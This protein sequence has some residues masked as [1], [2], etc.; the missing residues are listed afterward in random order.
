MDPARIESLRR[1]VVVIKYGGNA[2]VNESAESSVAGQ[3]ARLRELQIPVVLVHGGGPA[4]RRLLGEV[5]LESEFADGHR[6]TDS[7]AMR[8]VEMALCGEVNGALVSAL[9]RYPVRAVGLSGKD[10][11]MVSAVKRY[12]SV[13][14]GGESRKID[15]GQVGDVESVD[16]ELL[17]RLIESGFLPVIAPVA[18]GANQMDYNINADMF[19]GHIAGALKAKAYVAL[20]DVDALRSDPTDA[21]SAIHKI[22]AEEVKMSIGSTIE[23]GM[24]PK[25]ESC[26]IALEMGVAHAHIISGTQPGTLLKTLLSV[27]PCGTRIENGNQTERK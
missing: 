19:A 26:L 16:T 22:S 24:I 4:I 20:T 18:S 9:N 14:E 6:I 13:K 8:L 5:G 27:E 10:A 12:H 15:L 3:I 2:M 17:V 23:G 7:R 11:G 25:V 1:S 21:S